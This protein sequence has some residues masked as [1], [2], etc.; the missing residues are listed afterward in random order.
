[1][2]T[3]NP[4][5]HPFSLSLSLSAC[6][7]Y[8]IESSVSRGCIRDEIVYSVVILNSMLQFNLWPDKIYIQLF[9]HFSSNF[10]YAHTT[11]L[12]IGPHEQ[13]D[14]SSGSWLH[15]TFLE[16]KNEV[17]RSFFGDLPIITRL[18]KLLYIISW[19][20]NYQF[21]VVVYFLRIKNQS[22]V[23]TCM[24]RFK[25]RISFFFT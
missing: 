24:S 5:R 6:W 9:D 20:E 23:W 15:H 3:L 22:W 2:P 21:I 19:G 10:K 4:A 1:M 8:I 14:K 11:L 7:E 13:I 18:L 17:I 16:Y 25:P 12:F